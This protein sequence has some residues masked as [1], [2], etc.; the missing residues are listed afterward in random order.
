MFQTLEQHYPCPCAQYRLQFVKSVHHFLGSIAKS[1]I[2]WKVEAFT[3]N[4]CVMEDDRADIDKW[5]KFALSKGTKNLK[6]K[7]FCE[8]YIKSLDPQFIYIKDCFFPYLIPDYYVPD[9]LLI[10]NLTLEACHPG[11][12]LTTKN[13]IFGCLGFLKLSYASLSR[14]DFSTM[15]SCLQQLRTLHLRYCV[16]PGVINLSLLVSLESFSVLHCANLQTVKISSPKLVHFHCVSFLREHTSPIPQVQITSVGTKIREFSYEASEKS[17]SYI[18]TRLPRDMPKLRHLALYTRNDN[19]GDVMPLTTNMVA[20]A[21][22]TRVKMVFVV[23]VDLDLSKMIRALKAFPQLKK[24]RFVSAIEVP[25]VDIE[26]DEHVYERLEEIGFGGFCGTS[27]EIQLLIYFLAH[28]PSL[29]RLVIDPNVNDRLAGDLKVV[30]R[31]RLM[32]NE[33][34]QQVREK[35]QPFSRD[36][37]MLFK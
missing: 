20:F 16:L 37:E 36:V 14:H 30:E 2:P 35:L 24:L 4:F 18:F 33:E 22:I 26:H 3:I 23:R 1:S 27:N 13:P 9:N 10:N 25:L 7:L 12:G 19:W 15:F 6:I 34:R 11:R 31:R 21:H 8:K 32:E 5:V 28:A 29:K 17:L